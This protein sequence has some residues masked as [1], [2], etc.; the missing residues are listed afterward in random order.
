VIGG[1]RTLDLDPFFFWSKKKLI[2]IINLKIRKRNRDSSP[3]LLKSLISILLP[4][5]KHHE[6]RYRTKTLTRTQRNFEIY[7]HAIHN[8][9]IQNSSS[10]IPIPSNPKESNPFL[11]LRSSSSC[12][13]IPSDI[14]EP[15]CEPYYPRTQ[16][17]L[18]TLTHKSSSLHHIPSN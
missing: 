13:P 14:V 10:Y 17:L 1:C 7:L 5:C 18:W 11:F 4:S 15:N 3:K 12:N 8:I 2:I 9:E 16:K 6:P